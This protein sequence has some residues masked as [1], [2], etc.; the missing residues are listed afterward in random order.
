[1]KKRRP[2][3]FGTKTASRGTVRE[4]CVVIAMPPAL[5]LTACGSSTPRDGA[6]AA[7]A[8]RQSSGGS[9]GSVYAQKVLVNHGDKRF[10]WITLF[11]VRKKEG[12]L[13]IVDSDGQDYED[14][15]DFRANNDL[16]SE[17]DRITLPRDFPSVDR[18]G[19]LE[20]MTVS[21]HTS[22]SWA[23]WLIGGT[24][25]VLISGTGLLWSR[26]RRGNALFA[27][28]ADPQESSP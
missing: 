3:V 19:K 9:P 4:L 27:A 25:L 7:S 13:A 28:D 24:A 6:P 12:G 11:I 15:D 23:W 14:L 17:K 10:E 26:A 2:F 1:V 22:S 20:L 5:L 16:L 21:G 18:S 8:S